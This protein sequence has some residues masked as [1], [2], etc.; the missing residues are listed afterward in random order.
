VNPLTQRT[1]TGGTAYF[2]LHGVTG[3]RYRHSDD[4]LRRLADLC[5]GFD[6]AYCLFNNMTMVEDAARFMALTSVAATTTG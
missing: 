1:V 5:A 4:D 2:R 6:E 3:Y